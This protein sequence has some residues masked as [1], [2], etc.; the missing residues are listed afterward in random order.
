MGERLAR[1]TAR[2]RELS[3]PF[4]EAYDDLV[5]RLV[6][7]DVGKNAPAVGETMPDFVLPEQ[8][9]HLLSLDDLVAEGPAVLSFNRGHWCPFC[10]IE[11]AAFTEHHAEFAN[12]GAAVCCVLPDRQ[13]F[14]G[15]LRA[16]TKGTLRI[17]S[18]IDNGYALS[19]GLVLWVGDKVKALMQGGGYR[20]DV[21]QG[22]DS[23]F[24]PLPATFVVGRDKTVL[25]RSVDP[26][27][28][29]RMEI[30]DIVAALRSAR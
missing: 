20:L 4:A 11:L 8:G 18:D 7:S 6:A 10:R 26:D 9:G 15:Q 16:E 23:W 22:N 1:F 14:T 27:F 28:R 29:R 30:G 24:L 12:L 3:F 13:Q 19:L 17:V 2:L 25:A 5:A 21:Y